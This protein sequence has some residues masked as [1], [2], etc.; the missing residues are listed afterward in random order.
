MSDATKA[1]FISYAREDTDAARRI[2]EALRS[3]GVEVWF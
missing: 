1:V 3:H 2:A